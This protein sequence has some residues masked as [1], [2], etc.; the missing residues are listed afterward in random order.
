MNCYRY[1]ISGY[2]QGV[3]Y[4]SGAQHAA[5]KLNITGYAKNLPSGDVEVVA[6]GAEADIEEFEKWLWRGPIIA[7][8]IDIK[9]QRIEENTGFR[10]FVTY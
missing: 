8:V 5:R 4:R 6:R 10:G 1:I 7:D 2:V 9:K 3:C